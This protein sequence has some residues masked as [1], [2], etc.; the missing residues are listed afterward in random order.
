MTATIRTR[1]E[2]VRLFGDQAT[3]NT[4]KRIVLDCTGEWHEREAITAEN[5]V[6]G[7]DDPTVVP[8]DGSE[9]DTVPNIVAVEEKCPNALTPDGPVCPRCGGRRGPSGVD[10]GSWV[11]Y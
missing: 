9:D 8:G 11:H 10:G 3:Y 7:S 1:D 4:A 6:F 2:L 5:S